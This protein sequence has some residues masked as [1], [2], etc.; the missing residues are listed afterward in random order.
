M[1]TDRYLQF[2]GLIIAIL[3]FRAEFFIVSSFALIS[4]FFVI[5]PFAIVLFLWQGLYQSLG[6]KKL[7]HLARLRLELSMGIGPF[8][9]R[10]IAKASKN[11]LK[12]YDISPSTGLPEQHERLKG[13]IND[14]Y[15]I[16]KYVP[17]FFQSSLNAVRLGKALAN[18]DELTGP[19]R[20]A[21]LHAMQKAEPKNRP[22]GIIGEI[23]RTIRDTLG[24]L[25][26]N[27]LQRQRIS[28]VYTMGFI[29]KEIRSDQ[30]LD[31][32]FDAVRTARE[33]Q[34][35]PRFDT[36]SIDVI[37]DLP[38]RIQRNMVLLSELAFGILDFKR[39]PFTD[40]SQVKRMRI[41]KDRF[42]VFSP[43]PRSLWD[44]ESDQQRASE[45]PASA[46]KVIHPEPDPT[47]QEQ[48]NELEQE[49][50]DGIYLKR[51]WPIGVE[52]EGRSWLGGAPLLPQSVAWPRSQDHG[53]PLHFL[54]QIDCADLPRVAD[55]EAMPENGLL[56]FFASINEDMDWDAD[57]SETSVLYIPASVVPDTVVPFPTNLPDLGH[58]RSGGE[59]FHGMRSYPKWPVTA[60]PVKTY[61]HDHRRPLT[62]YEMARTL[63]DTELQAHLPEPQDKPQRLVVEREYMKSQGGDAVEATNPVR[64]DFRDFVS[65]DLVHIGFPFCGAV[66]SRFALR[67]KTALVRQLNRERKSKEYQRQD[68]RTEQDDTLVR[69]AS[70]LK[71]LQEAAERLSALGDYEV[72][73]KA[74][75]EWFV[76]WLGDFATS[77]RI[78]SA[79]N[80]ALLSIV[81]QSVTDAH[82]RRILPE[83]LFEFFDDAL[84]PTTEQSEHM[85][86]G[87]PQFKTNSTRSSGIRLLAL[88]SDYGLNF[89]FC[90]VGMIEFWIDPQDLENLD[91]SRVRVLTAG[92]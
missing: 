57:G 14:A 87:H 75:R 24:P 82:M 67:L 19:E 66:M 12:A 48:F 7:R 18:A 43:P 3:W 92:G 21:F 9:G 25:V 52:I 56:L 35:L 6:P 55:C 72:P 28:Y 60:H 79:L 78:N 45:R 20:Q 40:P 53:A 27:K 91:F 77:Y 47:L 42:D 71:L 5:A 23:K 89:M 1:I 29:S 22:V 30:R 83:N 64:Q 58:G 74:T 90:D 80:G 50:L 32:L 11:I 73:D 26:G 15:K 62:Q 10:R 41:L 63:Q 2:I 38:L 34:G 46:P 51:A 16:N 31:T 49:A 39:L 69:L 37:A 70:S 36:K 61:Y 68:G 59:A 54:A 86:L 44:P 84:R 65:P 33:A 81:Q 13:L 76:N 8:T 4:I 88:D 85:M 17:P